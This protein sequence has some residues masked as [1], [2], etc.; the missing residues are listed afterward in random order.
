MQALVSIIM[1]VKNAGPYLTDCLDSILAQSHVHW[2]LIAVN[3]HSDDDSEEILRAYAAVDPRINLIK[4]REKGIISA[5]RLALD[6]SEGHYVTRMD[7]DD[8]MHP[9]KLQCMLKDLRAHGR[10]HVALGQVRYFAQNGVKDGYRR[11]EAWLNDLSSE[12][13]NFQEL[14]KECVIPSPCFMV[15]MEDLVEAGGFEMETYPEDYD[16]AFRFYRQGYKCIPSNETLHYWRDYDTRT[17]RTHENYADNRFLDLK[18]NYFDE[19]H[20][21]PDREL[22]VWGAGAKGKV[23]AKWCIDAGVQFHWL[24]D[25]EKKI[26]KDIFEQ[27]MRHYSYLR[28]LNSPHVIVSVA[29]D[30]QQKAI[31]AYLENNGLESMQDY[32]CFC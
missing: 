22:A 17:S 20:R 27:R 6:F 25:N 21:N 8:F 7:A 30:E 15:H 13:N 28:E 12:G 9:M 16:L 18:L 14:Y 2:E 4:N 32:F 26:G 5:L 29:N 24:C 1:P 23:I 19:L 3:D 31:R 10:G 11:Y